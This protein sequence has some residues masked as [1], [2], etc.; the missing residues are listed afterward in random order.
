MANIRDPKPT[1]NAD[2]FAAAYPGD[3]TAYPNEPGWYFVIDGWD[4]L[5]V[6]EIDDRHTSEGF[7]TFNVMYM[8][9]WFT[10]ADAAELG[11]RWYKIPLP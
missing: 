6:A 5:R 10:P 11:L 7:Y 4:D 1:P 3:H 8:D 9:G 2:R